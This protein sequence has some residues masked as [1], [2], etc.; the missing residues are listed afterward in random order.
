MTRIISCILPLLFYAFTI[1]AFP[2]T[3]DP[4]ISIS[5]MDPAVSPGDDFYLYANGAYIARTKLPVDRATMGVF[6]TLLDL[7]FKQIAGIIEDASKANA[8]AGSDERKI[9]DLYKSYMDEA[10]IESHGLPALK[11][12]LAEID[13][14]RTPHDLARA[15]GQSIR[16]DVDALNLGQFHTANLF[17]LWVAPSFNDPNHY[18]PYLMQGG[19]GLS[20]RDYYLSDAPRMKQVRDAYGKHLAAVFHLLGYANADERATAVLALE[21]AIAQKQ[22]SLAD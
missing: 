10:A 1:S 16:A 5:N 22:V 9:A 3:Q 13:A 19:L 17:G 7:S 18:A 11:P 20:S 2:Q 4:G 14:I 6:N 15:L 21:T 8:P 12:H